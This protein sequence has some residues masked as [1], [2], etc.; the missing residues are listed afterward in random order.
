MKKIFLVFFILS[1]LNGCTIRIV[2]VPPRAYSLESA[3]KIVQ[4][5]YVLVHT[6]IFDNYEGIDARG[7]VA[8]YRD[9]KG[10]MFLFYGLKRFDGSSKN[11][12]K[13]IVKKYGVWNFGIYID[14]PSF[15]Y[16]STKKGGKTI[17]AWWKDVWLFVVESSENS[18]GF[19]RD[20]MNAF[21]EV[22]GVLR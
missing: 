14:L 6:D 17:T 13:S 7:T 16:Y 5:K 18:K 15:G 8:I 20:V 22:G 12:W 1:V 10:Q 19:V 3:V 2:E 11:L 9:N 4:G 21:A